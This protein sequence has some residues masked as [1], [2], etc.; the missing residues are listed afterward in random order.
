MDNRQIDKK[1]T[2]QIRIDAGL[3]RILKTK[4]AKAGISIKE[5]LEQCLNESSTFS[6]GDY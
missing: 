6:D 2:K 3:H 4:A 5:F 1:I